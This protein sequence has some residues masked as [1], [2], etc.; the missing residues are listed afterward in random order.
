VARSERDAVA[1]LTSGRRR[2][3][4]LPRGTAAAF[5][6]ATTRTVPLFAT[7]ALLVTACS[8]SSG[9]S[10]DSPEAAD[11]GPPAPNDAVVV[12]LWLDGAGAA[13]VA[14]HVSSFTVVGGGGDV[15]TDSFDCPLAP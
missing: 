5:G 2:N 11:A 12:G 15:V 10:S 14:A 1:T 8:D 13:P 4:H 3:P 7:L 9:P 6:T